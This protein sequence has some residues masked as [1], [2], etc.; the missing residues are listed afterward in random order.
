MMTKRSC[1]VVGLR[2]G[3][4]MLAVVLGVGLTN[5]QSA[6]GHCDVVAGRWNTRD[7]LGYNKLLIAYAQLQDGPAVNTSDAID[8]NAMREEDKLHRDLLLSG[9]ST[10]FYEF[11]ASAPI[12]ERDPSGLSKFCGWYQCQCNDGH[13]VYIKAYGESKRAKI[14]NGLNNALQG[15]AVNAGGEICFTVPSRHG[16]HTYCT[17]SCDDIRKSGVMQHECGHACDAAHGGVYWFCGW[18]AEI[19]GI[20]D[21][22]RG[23]IHGPQQCGGPYWLGPWCP[24]F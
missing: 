1:R 10:R 8:R 6:R 13:I 20:G 21:P 2:A 14:V 16:A 19:P 11:L 18:M 9:I 12:E 17:V 5:A 24:H 23:G 15:R 4:V 3:G 7:P 22:N